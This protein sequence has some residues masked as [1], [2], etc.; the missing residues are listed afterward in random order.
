MK[1]FTHCV[2]VDLARKAQSK[3]VIA[4]YPFDLDEMPKRAFAF[5]HDV[6]GFQALH[7]YILKIV[8]KDSLKDVAINMEPTG[9]WRDVSSFFQNLGAAVFYTRTDVV[10]GVRK[11]H[12]R[13][14]KT[15]RIDSFSLAGMP[16]IFPKRMI[17]FSPRE[18][19]LEIL[20]QYASQRFQIVKDVTRWK[21]RLLARLELVWKPL[22]VSL[23]DKVAFTQSMRAFWK[24]FPH[25]A[26]LIQLGVKRFSS[27]YK[28]HMHG[29][30]APQMQEIIWNAGLK[31]DSL[32]NLLR[33]GAG[34]RDT[35]SWMITK[36][37]DIITC[38]EKQQEA[39][40]KEIEK[41]REKVPECSLV[42][43]IP[44]V[45]P[46]VSVNLASV[47]APV[48]RFSN[49]R[50]CSAYTGL[51]CRKKSSGEKEILGL[52]ITKA[53]N[54]RVKRDLILAADVAMHRDPQ[55]AAFA[56]RLFTAGKHYNKVR[57][58]VGRKIAVR[59]YSLLKRYE[60]GEKNVH[61]EFRD[62]KGKPVSQEKAKALAQSL[63]L[64]YRDHGKRMIPAG[65]K[66]KSAES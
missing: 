66:R 56:I 2:G 37:L 43:E 7:A 44:G 20:S 47:L 27:W 12:S 28:N 59:A 24:R 6:E 63:W 61:Y 10:S 36:D 26:D 46:V 39:I 35:L 13:Y 38:L 22:L 29:A 51:V 1:H 4:S 34:E 11:A 48:S 54:R 9:P 19:R 8:G 50:K 52:R 45:G 40:E 41:A 55:L 18:E 14:A 15:D 53:G 16:R 30:L 5:S 23:E 32:W 57:V 33:K 21:N 49:T 17:L 58:A 3:A 42:D 25:P 31:A 62:L 65:Q 60:K 64:K